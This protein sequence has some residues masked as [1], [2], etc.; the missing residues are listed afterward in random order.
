MRQGYWGNRKVCCFWVGLLFAALIMVMITPGP[1]PALDGRDGNAYVNFHRDRLLDTYAQYKGLGN[2]VNAWNTFN[3]KQKWLFLHQTDLLGNRTYMNPTPKYYYKN[4]PADGC[5]SGSGYCGS[6]VVRG[7]QLVCGSC[8]VWDP[9]TPKDQP[10][11]LPQC[12]TISAYDCYTNGLCWEESQTRTDYTMALENVEKLYA[13]LGYGGVNENCG[14]EDNNR[15]F[16]QAKDPLI[17]A[18]RNRTMPEWANNKDELKGPHSPFD[19]ASATLTGRPW[20]QDGPD[21]QAQFYSWDTVCS[22][23][24]QKGCSPIQ[25]FVRGGAYLPADSRMFELDNDYNIPHDSS[26]L[27]Y[28]GG[29]YAVNMYQNQWCSKK[30][31]AA[32]CDWNYTPSA[33]NYTLSVSKSGTGSGTVTSNPAGINCGVTCSANYSG[34]TQVTLMATASAGS[35]FAGWSGPCSG[36]GTC[37]VTIDTAKS[38]SATFNQGGGTPYWCASGTYP[39]YYYGFTNWLCNPAYNPIYCLTASYQWTTCTF[40]GGG[41]GGSSSVCGNGIC[42]PAGNENGTSCPQDCCDQSTSCG[43]TKQNDGVHYCR[44]MYYYEWQSGQA[45]W[46]G[47]QW[48]TANDTT[49]VCNDWWEAQEGAW[50]QT[51]YQC[52]GSTGKCHSI[53]GGYY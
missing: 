26:P 29:Q 24:G 28:Y 18:F 31:N 8:E 39:W 42:E 47:W 30:G 37:T 13:I 12:W 5:G 35:T 27:C 23:G 53:P 3:E 51:Q 34:G 25:G 11:Q 40:G 52:G 21:G 14:G 38:V 1:S 43:Q 49:Q 4:N 10:Q 46:H 32:P 2:R 6:C 44:N 22:Y 7:G 16:W 15:I 50:Y 20:A 36:T 41:G 9:P 19:N 17:Q 45:Y 48:V 33:V